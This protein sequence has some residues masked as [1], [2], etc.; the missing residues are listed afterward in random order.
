MD[1]SAFAADAEPQYAPH[2]TEPLIVSVTRF[3]PVKDIETSVRSFA[4][5]R[6]KIPGARYCIV[7]P[8]NGP[9]NYYHLRIR[10]LIEAE[11][12]EG[13][14]IVGRVSRAEL[15]NY[16]RRATLLLH[17]ARTLPDD[18][19][20]SGLILLEAGLFG[21]PVVASASG[22]IP[23]VV[24]HESTGLLAPEGDADALAAAMLR[25][26]SDPALAARLG[27]ANRRRA[28]ERNWS[29]YMGEQRRLYDEALAGMKDS[30]A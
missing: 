13:V 3:I 18:F 1:G 8:G 16:Y 21:L 5:L 28:L 23:E 15:E 6:A 4:R 12:I 26:I 29:W 14:E 25:L 19:E 27:A 10:R 2:A 11:R 7:G 9:R 17:T 24:A 20:A 30:R 22:G